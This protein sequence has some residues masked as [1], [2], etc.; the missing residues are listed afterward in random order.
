MRWALQ[1]TGATRG[2]A[3][4]VPDQ[5]TCTQAR[6]STASAIDGLS[7]GAGGRQREMVA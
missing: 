6:Q 4:K 3:G 2:T 5:G 7:L 1:A